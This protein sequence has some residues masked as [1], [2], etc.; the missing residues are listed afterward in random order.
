M[1]FY[2][3]LFCLF[4]FFA[5]DW[6]GFVLTEFTFECFFVFFFFFFG[7]GDDIEVSSMDVGEVLALT[8]FVSSV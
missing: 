6:V 7:G 2:F 5:W 3:V 4:N 8:L 1:H